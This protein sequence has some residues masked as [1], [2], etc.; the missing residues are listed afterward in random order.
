MTWR[1]L[2]LY[3]EAPHLTL[4]R[5][6]ELGSRVASRFAAWRMFF[7]NHRRQPTPEG[8]QCLYWGIR[9]G[10]ITA[11]AWKIDLG[12]VDTPT[13]HERLSHSRRIAARLTPD[14]RTTIL[15]LKAQLWNHPAYRDATTSQDIYEAV[16]GAGVNGLE[17]FW[18]YV[19]DRSVG[20]VG[21]NV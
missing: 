11:G 19:R 17:E 15:A 6:F 12:A 16:L 13:C 3:L 8:L 10:D 7:T 5:F 1:D 20:S 2:D 14:S 18:E 4:E 9:L 21:L